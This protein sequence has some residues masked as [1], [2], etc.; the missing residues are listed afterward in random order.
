MGSYVT[1]ITDLILFCN[2]AGEASNFCI[3]RQVLCKGTH[4]FV[5]FGVSTTTF[6]NKNIRNT[7]VSLVPVLFIA[8]SREGVTD[9]EATERQVE[10]HPSRKQRKKE[11][12][13]QRNV[14]QC[15]VELLSMG[16]NAC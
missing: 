14:R 9:K 16:T 11:L 3:F 12:L 5:T 2:F 6:Q 7:C 8:T 10:S 13:D 15:R 1:G 4:H